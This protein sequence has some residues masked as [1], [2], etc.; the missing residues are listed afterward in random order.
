MAF[1]DLFPNAGDADL[2]DYVLFFSIEED[3]NAQGN[4]SK[5]R[6]SYQHVA[7]GAGYTHTLNLKM[8][9]GTGAKLSK[10]IYNDEG[11]TLENKGEV[12]STLSASDLANGFELLPSSNKTLSVQNNNAAHANNLKLG[13]TVSFELSFDQPVPRAKIGSAP[14]DLYIY[15]NNTK[16]NIHFPGKYFDVAGKDQF[17][18]KNGFPWAIIVPG[19]WKWPLEGKDIRNVSNTGYIDFAAWANSKGTEKKTWYSNI[20]DASKVFPLPDDS[21]LA[22]YLAKAVQENWLSA[23]IG[24]LIFGLSIGYFLYAEI[25]VI[26]PTRKNDPFKDATRSSGSIFLL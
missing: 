23:S 5:I 3:M 22:G 4:I 19:K 25:K 7:R 15:V 6:G 21:N 17:L 12:V 26:F 1:E 11:K 13:Y 16:R 14:Y 18:D 2:N 20:T 9:A 10:I 24:L 8:N